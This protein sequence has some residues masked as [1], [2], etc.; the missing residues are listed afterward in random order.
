VPPG[1]LTAY[2]TAVIGE[3]PHLA[4]QGPRLAARPP[5]QTRRVRRDGTHDAGVASAGATPWRRPHP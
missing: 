2:G 1:A 5:P 4:S 3:A